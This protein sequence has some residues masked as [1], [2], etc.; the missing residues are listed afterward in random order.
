MKLKHKKFY[1]LLISSLITIM[2][3]IIFS[4]GLGVVLYDVL[5]K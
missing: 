1:L 2:T 3:F 4:V 5:T